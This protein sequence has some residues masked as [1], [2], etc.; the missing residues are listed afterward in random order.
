MKPDSVCVTGAGGFIGRA[1]V[2]HLEQLG[3]RVRAA[4]R[5]LESG[6]PAGVEVVPGMALSSDT[7]WRPALA[8]SKFLVHAAARVH[9]I[10]ER[11]DDP[12]ADFRRVNVD[13]TMH[14]AR[15]AAQHGVQRFIYLSSIGVNGSQTF[16]TPFT[17]EDQPRPIASYARSKHEAEQGLLEIS[18]A[19]GMELVILRPPLVYGPNAPGNFGTLVR[20]LRRRVPLPLASIRNQRSLIG[21]DNLVALIAVCLTHPNAANRLFLASDGEDLSTPDLLRRLGGAL[22]RP[23]RLFPFPVSVLRAGASMVGRSAV[24]EQLCGS[25]QVDARATRTI[26]GWRPHLTLDQGLAR[27][28]GN[29]R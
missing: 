23:A 27:V 11:S 20:C 12:L 1:L 17:A 24:A 6:F 14:L 4:V 2:R 22:G 8:G 26:L 3:W 28:A 18:A 21:L 16:D 15:Q 25:L 5:R 13:A 9:V 19:S 10:R 29:G 7:D